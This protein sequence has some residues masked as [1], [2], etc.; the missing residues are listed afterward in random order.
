MP[1]APKDSMNNMKHDVTP[2]VKKPRLK[3]IRKPSA[4]AK[5]PVVEDKGWAKSDVAQTYTK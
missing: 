5:A 1:V 3:K 2:V 4:S